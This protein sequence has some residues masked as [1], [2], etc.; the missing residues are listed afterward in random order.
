MAVTSIM[1]TEEEIN[2][3]AGANASGSFTEAMKDAAVLQAETTVNVMT[4]YNWSD[5]Y[6]GL[7]VDVKHILSSIVSGMVAQQWISYDMSGYTSRYEA[8][9]MLDVLRDSIMRDLSILRDIKAQTF[10]NGA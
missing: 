9:T 2:A 8:E 10:T 7:N 4:R 1:T 3:K 5:A 6:A